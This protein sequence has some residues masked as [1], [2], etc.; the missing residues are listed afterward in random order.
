MSP[1]SPPPPP[2]AAAAILALVTPSITPAYDSACSTEE[3]RAIMDFW[4]CQ[5]P[6]RLVPIRKTPTKLTTCTSLSLDV[7]NEDEDEE[8]ASL[9]P[10]DE[11]A[12]L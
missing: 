1:P 5:F 11:T 8:A 9:V 2:A 4:V 10:G 12:M 3:K 7:Q 6:W